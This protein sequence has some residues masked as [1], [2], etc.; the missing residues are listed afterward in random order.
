MARSIKIFKSFE[1]Q[2]KWFLEYFASLTPSER[3][4]SLSELQKKNYPSFM[5]PPAR[6][7]VILKHFMHGY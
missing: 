7:V 1:E 3:L 6:Q 2:E 5:K 4:K